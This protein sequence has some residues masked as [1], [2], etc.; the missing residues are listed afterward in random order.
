MLP[1]HKVKRYRTIMSDATAPKPGLYLAIHDD[2]RYRTKNS[3]RYRTKV[4]ERY[5][6]KVSY[7]YRTK[8]GCPR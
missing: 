1:H 4:G 3:Y 2:W 8:I 6:T 7:R 5:R